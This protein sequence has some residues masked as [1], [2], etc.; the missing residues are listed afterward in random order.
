MLKHVLHFNI[1]HTVEGGRRE[2]HVVFWWRNLKERWY[3]ED[4]NF[5]WEHN[6]KI[7]LKEIG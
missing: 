6:I 3:L 1:S 2:I 4:L 7:G 5:S